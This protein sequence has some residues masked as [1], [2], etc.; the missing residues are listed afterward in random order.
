MKKL[1]SVLLVSVLLL[2]CIALGAVSV[3][4]A[5]SGDYEYYI[6]DGEAIISGVKS[7]ISGDITIPSKLGGYPVTA[8]DYQAFYNF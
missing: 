1:L 3:S 7:S 5:T 2:T 8:I 6:I 4:A